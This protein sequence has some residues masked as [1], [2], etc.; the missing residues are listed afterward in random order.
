MPQPPDRA[1]RS[2]RAVALAGVAAL[3]LTAAPQPARADGPSEDYVVIATTERAADAVAERIDGEQVPTPQGSPAEAILVVAE[4]TEAEA[5]AV[6]D[7]PDVEAVVP[8]VRL[9]MA[10]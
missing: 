5:A 6:E 10:P 8:D 3:L 9:R 1:P 7:R 4:L 2:T